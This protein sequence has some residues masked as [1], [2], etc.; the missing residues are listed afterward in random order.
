VQRWCSFCFFCDAKPLAA[1]AHPI[2]D[3]TR[4]PANDWVAA[5]PTNIQTIQ[6]FLTDPLW[7]AIRHWGSACYFDSR[8]RKMSDM[9]TI[10]SAIA[11][12]VVA[13]R[14]I[15]HFRDEL[16][17]R[18]MHFG[19]RERPAEARLAR[20]RDGE[21]HLGRRQRREA[22]MQQRNLTLTQSLRLCRYRWSSRFVKARKCQIMRCSVWCSEA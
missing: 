22:A 2:P 21:R 5:T 10:L 17:L 14:Q 8:D 7:S 18:P 9:L 12:P 3:S 19:Q 6:K 13:P 16:R 4:S 1:P 11:S 15:A 20:R